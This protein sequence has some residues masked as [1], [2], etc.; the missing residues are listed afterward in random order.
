MIARFMKVMTAERRPG[1]RTPDPGLRT[2]YS[3]RPPL[4]PSPSANTAN[5]AASSPASARRAFAARVPACHGASK[6]RAYRAI[7]TNS[8]A[9]TGSHAIR[10]RIQPTVSGAVVSPATAVP[11]PASEAGTAAAS[12]AVW[13]Q[14]RIVIADRLITTTGAQSSGLRNSRPSRSRSRIAA[15]LCAAASATTSSDGGCEFVRA[16]PG[17]PTIDAG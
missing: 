16:S 7:S 12:I 3:G 2:P 17:T 9:N 5:P 13:C 4:T 11:A 14:H 6:R 15:P 10:A 1:P 8:P